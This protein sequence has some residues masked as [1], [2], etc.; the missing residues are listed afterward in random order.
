[1]VP[2]DQVTWHQGPGSATCDTRES[3]AE[4]T[5]L[6]RVRRSLLG[7]RSVSVSLAL[8]AQFRELGSSS[9]DADLGT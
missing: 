4:W 6:T 3:E 8:W 7:F 2:P 9:A 1:M 5:H